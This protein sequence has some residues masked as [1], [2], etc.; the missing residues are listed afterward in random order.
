MAG[1]W[2]VSCGHPPE[3][4]P[5]A[6]GRRQNLSGPDEGVLEAVAGDSAPDKAASQAMPWPL[7][8]HKARNAITWRRPLRAPFARKCRPA[9][10][11]RL[12]RAKAS[13][14]LDDV[15]AE[16]AWPPEAGCA[17]ITGSSNCLTEH[18]AA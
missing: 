18:Q 14:D 17:I 1:K 10:T 4:D 12:L 16:E 13:R 3:S 7:E 9:G 15:A 8:G 11:R 6:K 2:G 5:C